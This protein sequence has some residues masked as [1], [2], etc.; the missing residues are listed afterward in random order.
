MV[1]TTTDRHQPKMGEIRM[2][3]TPKIQEEAPAA[4][5]TLIPMNVTGA[6]RKQLRSTTVWPT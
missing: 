1:D 2:T 6:K 4:P 3:T 5:R